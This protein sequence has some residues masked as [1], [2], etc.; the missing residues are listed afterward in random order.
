MCVCVCLLRLIQLEIPQ[1]YIFYCHVGSHV[2]VLFFFCA[3]F[4]ATDADDFF[5]LFV[6]VLKMGKWC[7]MDIIS[8]HDSLYDAEN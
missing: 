6:V 2:V 8:K 3:T 1:F 5:F 7:M 4:A